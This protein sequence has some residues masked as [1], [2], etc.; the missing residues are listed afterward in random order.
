VNDF[1]AFPLDVGAVLL[2]VF[3]AIVVVALVDRR[4]RI[5]GRQTGAAA[6]ARR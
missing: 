5:H 1:V 4:R 3:A 2:L 6:R